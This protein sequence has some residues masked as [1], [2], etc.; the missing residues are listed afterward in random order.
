M[1]CRARVK[2]LLNFALPLGYPPPRVPPEHILPV[3]FTV[4]FPHSPSL[5]PFP[6]CPSLPLVPVLFSSN[7]TEFL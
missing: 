6:D 3:S 1:L 2:I 5:A 4:A 7:P